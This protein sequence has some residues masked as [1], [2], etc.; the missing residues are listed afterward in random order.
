MLRSELQPKPFSVLDVFAIIG[1]ATMVLIATLSIVWIVAAHTWRDDSRATKLRELEKAHV[2]APVEPPVSLSLL[3]YQN[4][5]FVPPPRTD[6]TIETSLPVEEPS[7]P[8]RKTP[9]VSGRALQKPHALWLDQ[10]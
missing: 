10:D 5:L 1:V 8:P 6:Q 3:A 9:T 7:P 2:A 4:D